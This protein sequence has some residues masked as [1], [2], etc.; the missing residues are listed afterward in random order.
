MPSRPVVLAEPETRPLPRWRTWYHPFSGALILGV[1]FLAFGTE[2]ASGFLDTPA[3][4]LL[5]FAAT[6]PAVYLSQRRL[7]GDKAAPA[8][9]KALLGAVLAG[10][11]F[12]I[13]GGI[14]GALVLMLSGLP[15]P[16]GVKMHLLKKA[17]RRRS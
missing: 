10:L 6:L 9:L 7:A 8:L 11:P 2:F 3:V 5:A 14:F 1:D 13:E 16:A 4:S 17:L 15:H 12:S